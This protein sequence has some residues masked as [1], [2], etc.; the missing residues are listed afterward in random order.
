MCGEWLEEPPASPGAFRLGAVEA[1]VLTCEEYDL[2]PAQR[3]VLAHLSAEVVAALV[4]EVVVDDDEVRRV[5]CSHGSPFGGAGGGQQLVGLLKDHP[6]RGLPHSLAVFNEEERLRHGALN[7][8]GAW[9]ARGE[10][11]AGSVAAM[12]SQRHVGPVRA[13]PS[14]NLRIIAQLRASTYPAPRA[15]C[16]EAS[17][18][19]RS[20]KG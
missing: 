15:L 8:A 4:G 7:Q 3:W 10:P 20:V 13:H 16:G 6:R 9:S 1:V 19:G 18:R 5:P 14:S 2:E 17:D 12:G 11:H